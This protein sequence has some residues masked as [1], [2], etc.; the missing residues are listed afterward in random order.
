MTTIPTLSQLYN[1][2]LA[3][4][5]AQYG[6][7]IPLF[8]KNFLRTKAAV[9]AGKLKLIYLAIGILQ[10]NIFVDTADPEALGGT[11]ERFGRVKLGRNP[12]SATAG[13]YTVQVTG[14]V[15]ATIP[16]SS[17]W[18]SNDDASSPGK[19]FILDV[20]YTLVS[21]TDSITLRALESGVNSK[22]Q[23]GN[24][25]TVTA[26]IANVNSIGEV[27]AE[28]V[29]PTA[30]EDIE[31][32][33]RKA[34]NSYRLEPQGGAATDYRLWASDAEGVREVYPYASSGN[35]NEIDVFVEANLVDSTDGKGTPGTTIL[36]N[37]A[38]V[39]EFDPDTTLELSERGRRPLGVYA[40]NCLPVQ[41]RD[42]DITI[43]GFSGLTTS[44][45]TLITNA[46]KDRIS[47]IRPFVAGADILADKDDTLDINVII[48][49]ILNANPGS[50]FTSVSMTIDNVTETS[51]TFD[52]GNIPYVASVNF[53]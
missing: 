33:R 51:Y 24:Q 41:V 37:V 5:E 8:G 25:L 32:Y 12:F 11:L 20:A 2:I 42:I 6:V 26:P 34:L 53:A 40:V 29:E 39:I 31:E 10:K 44:L 17:T 35:A 48:F 27:T 50:I 38:A 13:Q 52:N 30:A 36:N 15:G 1:G 14:T 9:Q 21:T 3:S 46:L 49:T 18:K 4:L 19:M 45:Q 47:S 7:T 16:A 23:V 28:A 43:T 22:L